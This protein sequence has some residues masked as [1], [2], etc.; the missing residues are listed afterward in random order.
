MANRVD[1]NTVSPELR[2]NNIAV[3]TPSRCACPVSSGEVVWGVRATRPGKGPIYRSG[4]P[5][6]RRG[7]QRRAK[8]V[9]VGSGVHIL[10]ESAGVIPLWNWLIYPGEKLM[11][12]NSVFRWIEVQY[13]DAEVRLFGFGIPWIVWFILVSWIT[14]FALRK[15]FGVII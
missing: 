4:L 13:P 6:R 3:A 14:V 5:G 2:G 15:T 9:N 11:P 7:R 10:S 8:S 1:L 12:R